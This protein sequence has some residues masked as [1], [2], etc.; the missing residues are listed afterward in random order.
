M[1]TGVTA[2]VT[3]VMVATMPGLTPAELRRL[4]RLFE[5]DR[6]TARAW[7]RELRDQYGFSGGGTIPNPPWRPPPP[8]VAAPP[9]PPGPPPPPEPEPEPEPE[10]QPEP[11]PEPEPEPQP[12]PE[13]DQESQSEPEA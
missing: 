6:A 11:Q 7:W 10:P 4:N 3:E 1:A 9:D 8:P 12:A 5:R 2:P 13:P